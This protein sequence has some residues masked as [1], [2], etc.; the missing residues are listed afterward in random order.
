MATLTRAQ[1][2]DKRQALANEENPDWTSPEANEMI[3][4]VANMVERIKASS[5]TDSKTGFSFPD[6]IL[7]KA[8]AELWKDEFVKEH[9]ANPPTQR[10]V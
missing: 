5:I 8:I 7:Y 3:Q 9:E 1:L 2:A 10:F 6:R 4:K